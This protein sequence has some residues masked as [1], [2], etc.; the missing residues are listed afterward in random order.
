MGLKDLFIKKEEEP[1]VVKS[2]PISRPQSLTMTQSDGSFSGYFDK[3][4]EAN[5]QQG[6]DFLE[7]LKTLQANAETP[8]TED[9]KY[10]ISFSAFAAQGLKPDDLI[11]SAKDYLK[12][13]EEEFNHFQQELTSA[14]NKLVNEPSSEITRLQQENEKLASEIQLNN[15]KIS[16]MKI[17]LSS[18]QNSL[19]SKKTAFSSEYQ[20][21]SEN[22]NRIITNIKTYLNGT[23]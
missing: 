5:N 14:E 19:S 11:V 4:M 15:N 16:E 8:L 9:Q 2:T 13:F 21:S 10:K 7:F 6:P 20:R 18:N 1:K 23:T 22:V 12:K 3:I 17:K